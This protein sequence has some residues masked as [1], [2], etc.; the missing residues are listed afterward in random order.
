M[1]PGA[2]CSDKNEVL[3]TT[4]RGHVPESQLVENVAD[5]DMSDGTQ[6]LQGLL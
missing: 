3:Y 6:L 4:V 2:C 1:G 5:G